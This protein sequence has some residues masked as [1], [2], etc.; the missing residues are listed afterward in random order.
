MDTL[1]VVRKMLHSCTVY[2]VSWI[3][4]TA[5][6]ISAQY[7]LWELHWVGVIDWPE[8]AAH[9]KSHNELKTHNNYL[10]YHDV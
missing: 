6:C 7:Y 3:L 2:F 8:Q 1:E 4:D 10:T 5:N 9:S